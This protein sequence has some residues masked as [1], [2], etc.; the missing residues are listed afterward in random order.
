MP[1]IASCCRCRRAIAPLLPG[2]L[3][4]PSFFAVITRPSRG[5]YRV[6]VAATIAIM[7]QSPLP[8]QLRSC[9]HRR[10]RHH[11]RVTITTAAA[12]LAC[13]CVDVRG[14]ESAGMCACVRTDMCV[15]VRGW[16]AV[17]R[18]ADMRVRIIC[19]GYACACVRMRP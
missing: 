13:I 2:R 16:V 19:V 10:R 7:A 14:R 4:A 3:P 9:R 15:D 12:A 8:S 18:R 17:R 1:C 11:H 5:S 6:A